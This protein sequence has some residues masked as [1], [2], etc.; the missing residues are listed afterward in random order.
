VVVTGIGAVTGAG[1]GVGAFRAAIRSGRTTIGPFSRF[2]HDAQRTHVASETPPTPAGPGPFARWRRLSFSDR[3]ALFAAYEAVSQAGLP[4]PLRTIAAG[5][6]FGSS[7]GGL[8]ETERFYEQLVSG[9]PA[10]SD[11]A[12]LASHQ[13]SA[14]AETV[15]RRLQ[16]HGPVETVSSAC[17]SASLAIE[18]ALGAVRSGE[19]DVAVT[20]GADCLSLTTYSGF[21]ALQ[22]MDEAPCRPFRAGRLGMSL[23][24]GG[25][26]LVLEGLDH[27]MARG[28]VPIAELLGA[29]S[30]CDATHMTAPLPAGTWAMTAAITDAGLRPSDIDY[31]N[32][33]ATGTPLNDAAE[34]AAMRLVFGPALD[35]MPI[36]ATKSIVGHLLGAAGAIEAIAVILCLESGSAHPAAGAGDADPALPVNLV[37]GEPRPVPGLRHALSSSLG[38]GGANAAVVFG[39]WS[40]A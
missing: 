18:Q 2:A 40:P 22:A 21:N 35:R 33:H 14:P 24:E 9:S 31:V 10:G 5:V 8:F 4:V 17:A 3:F 30:S 34:Y 28:A 37:R 25:A 20:G 1:W 26:V 16:V 6:F 19:V 11:R 32:A 38:F 7:T 13:L 29:G 12:L 39:R 15:A 23:G 36:E 27:A